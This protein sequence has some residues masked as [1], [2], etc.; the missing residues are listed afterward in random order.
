MCGHECACIMCICMWACVCVYYV[1]MHVGMCAHACGA[2]CLNACQLPLSGSGPSEC[3]SLCEGGRGAGEGRGA[4]LPAHA[5]LAPP[6]TQG[7]CVCVR[8]E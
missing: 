3:V 7:P 1:H 8:E 4:V 5:S 6:T 2:T